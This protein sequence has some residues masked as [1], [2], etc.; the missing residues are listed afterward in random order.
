MLNVM[1]SYEPYTSQ[2]D[3]TLILIVNVK[4]TFTNA[5]QLKYTAQACVLRSLQFLH[6][7]QSF[8]LFNSNVITFWMKKLK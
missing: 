8:Y 1:H 6:K 5:K 2:D 3:T 7:Y 4:I